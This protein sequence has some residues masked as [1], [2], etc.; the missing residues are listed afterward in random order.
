MASQVTKMIGNC[1]VGIDE[2]AD[3][4]KQQIERQDAEL[5]TESQRGSGECKVVLLVFEKYF[6]RTGSSAGLTIL[7]TEADGKQTA[8]IIGS[9]GGEGL[10][11]VSWGVNAD[12]AAIA[13]NLL[14]G[15]GFSE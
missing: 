13:I 6:W 15:Q 2:L 9:A 12:F 4:L 11:N 8:D 1:T 14:E 7:L 3:M 5:V 10:F